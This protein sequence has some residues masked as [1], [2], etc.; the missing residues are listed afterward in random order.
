M[1]V[2]VQGEV[3][4]KGVSRCG[5]WASSIHV[6]WKLFRNVNHQSHPDLLSQELGKKDSDLRFNKI[7]MLAN[8]EVLLFQSSI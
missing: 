5:P 7:L 3:G 8:I 4:E 1:D 6:T 2:P